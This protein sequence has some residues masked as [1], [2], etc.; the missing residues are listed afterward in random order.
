MDIT[1]RTTQEFARADRVTM[2]ESG[3]VTIPIDGS[4]VAG[5][6][7]LVYDD[8]TKSYK[9]KHTMDTVNSRIDMK[10]FVNRL[11]EE[12][13]DRSHL[14]IQEQLNLLVKENRELKNTISDLKRELENEIHKREVFQ[15]NYFEHIKWHSTK[16]NIESQDKARLDQRF[17]EIEKRHRE[18][19]SVVIKTNSTP[20]MVEESRRI[21]V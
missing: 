2:D 4:T 6:I 3:R 16:A 15:S 18:L 17:L 21:A 14:S 1:T 10:S 20:D 8:E 13:D 7:I 11:K 5:N 9:V 19:D 12:R